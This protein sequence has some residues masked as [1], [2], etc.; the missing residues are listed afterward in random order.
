MSYHAPITFNEDWQCRTR[1][2]RLKP[3]FENSSQ[4]C[5]ACSYPEDFL[6]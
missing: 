5:F 1:S 6:A 3:E 2:L 4:C